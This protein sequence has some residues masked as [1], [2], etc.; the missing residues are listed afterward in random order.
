MDRKWIWI[1]VIAVIAYYAYKHGMLNSFL[2]STGA[3]GGGG[4][5]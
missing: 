5:G 4:R 2:H 3:G 1:I